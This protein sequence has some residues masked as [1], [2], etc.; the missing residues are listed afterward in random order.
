MNRPFSCPSTDL[1]EA[2]K[3]NPLPLGRL[4][5]P[6]FLLAFLGLTFAA[7]AYPLVKKVTVGVY[8]P[9]TE[10]WCAREDRSWN[11]GRAR[12]DYWC[13][14]SRS[15][16]YQLRQ[17]ATSAA[18][19]FD[20]NALLAGTFYDN[21][22]HYKTYDF[23]G[24]PRDWPTV[25]SRLKS[26]FFYNENKNWVAGSYYLKVELDNGSV[27]IDRW[28]DISDYWVGTW[29]RAYFPGDSF[30]WNTPLDLSFSGA[31]DMNWNTSTTRNINLSDPDGSGSIRTW[32]TSSNQDIISN[33]SLTIDGS[34]DNRTLN[35]RPSANRFGTCNVTVYANDGATERQSTDRKSVV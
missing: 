29:N 3:P 10:N 25:R 12:Y 21:S 1:R 31:V 28:Q 13:A 20:S 16:A 2:V 19:E 17:A 34:G 32:A 4:L 22:H 18:S 27:V 24:S 11:F 35:I 5:R 9:D 6:L 15:E 7:Q 26:V 30:D 23:G 8:V 33:G 14:D